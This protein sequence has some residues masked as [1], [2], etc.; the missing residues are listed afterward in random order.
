MLVNC[1]LGKVDLPKWDP[2]P[3]GRERA[4]GSEKAEGDAKKEGSGGQK[5]RGGR[6]FIHLL[7]PLN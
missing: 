5:S 4:P 6:V 7:T 2:L 3:C 1:Q